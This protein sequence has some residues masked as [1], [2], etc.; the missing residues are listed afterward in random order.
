LLLNSGLTE[1]GAKLVNGEH[2]LSERFWIAAMERAKQQFLTDKFRDTLSILEAI[3]SLRAQSAEFHD[4]LG[5]AWYETGDAR[6]ASDE[7]QQAIGL[8]PLNPDRYFE[9][10][11]LYLKHHTP[12]LAKNRF[13]AR[14][15][16]GAGFSLAMAWARAEPASR[17]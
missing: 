9:L 17:R 10:G 5:L 2:D 13:R 11:I 16:T 6:K 1:K 7:L 3:R 4:L 8:E 12:D 14:A 15:G